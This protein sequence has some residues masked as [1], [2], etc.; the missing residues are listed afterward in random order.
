[1][2]IQNGC[3]QGRSQILT[4]EPVNFRRIDRL[5]QIAIEKGLTNTDAKQFGKLTKTST[6]EYLLAYHSIDIDAIESSPDTS[7]LVRRDNNSTASAIAFFDWV[8]KLQ[9]LACFLAAVGLFVLLSQVIPNPLSLIPVR[10]TI[11]LGGQ[12]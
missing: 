1:M 3:P 5:K 8:D 4:H 12:E 10:V 2:T 6:W 7:E 11:Q 9:L